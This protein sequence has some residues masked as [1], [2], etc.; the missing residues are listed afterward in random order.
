MRVQVVTMIDSD[1]YETKYVD[2]VGTEDAADSRYSLDEWRSAGE[3]GTLKV[4]KLVEI[5]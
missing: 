2:W 4:Y 5:E 3:Y 1:G